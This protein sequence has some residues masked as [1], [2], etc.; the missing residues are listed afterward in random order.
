MIAKKE[1]S[2]A[3]LVAHAMDIADDEGLDAI[4]LR[5]ISKEFGVT[6]MALYWHV[7]N[8]DELLDAMGD[9]LFAGVLTDLDPGDPWLE[10]VRILVERLVAALRRRPGS[11]P[12]AYARVLRCEAGLRLS[13]AVFTLLLDDAGF[14][15]EDAAHIGAQALRTAVVLVADQ[16]GRT[17]GDSD[18]ARSAAHDAKRA[19][20]AAL[21]AGTYP[22]LHRIGV[23]LLDCDE[24][25]YFRIGVELY[26]AGVERLAARIPAESGS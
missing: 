19:Y 4:S 11:A 22:H 16:P 9:E 20:L 12:L 13:E 2:R 25:D 15:T 17:V 3:A 23:P 1:L 24:D 10:Q 21:P 18:E 5:R 7:Q 26:V 14:S 8:K 6:P